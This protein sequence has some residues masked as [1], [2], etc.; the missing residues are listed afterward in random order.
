MKNKKNNSIKKNLL[1]FFDQIIINSWW[2][3]L[4]ILCGY[5]TLN[6]FINKKETEIQNLENRLNELHDQK[7]YAENQREDYSLRI[8]S[9]ADPAWI[10]LVL[11]KELGV[12]PEGH[13]KVHFTNE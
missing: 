9:Q 10:E 12:V 8:N 7:I 13:I 2:V 3:Y 1:A 11:K 5:F 4:F 6:F